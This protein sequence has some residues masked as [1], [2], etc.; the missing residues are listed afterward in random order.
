MNQTAFIRQRDNNDK[1]ERQHTGKRED[2]NQD[3]KEKIGFFAK[4]VNSH[5]IDFFFL[6]F[7]G[8]HKFLLLKESRFFINSADN[9]VADDNEDTAHN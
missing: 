9:Q 4:G 1:E 2:G 6:N 8:F 7:W 3:V 5:I